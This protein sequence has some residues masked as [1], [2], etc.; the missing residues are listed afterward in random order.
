[1]DDPANRWMALKGIVA[2]GATMGIGCLARRMALSI[3]GNPTQTTPQGDLGL[4]LGLSALGVVLWIGCFGLEWWFVRQKSLFSRLNS[5]IL[6]FIGLVYVIYGF[7][8]IP[9]LQEAALSQWGQR[10]TA[11]V[12]EKPTTLRYDSD[13]GI[14]RNDYVLRYRYTLPQRPK[15]YDG[16]AGVK[17][18]YFDRIPQGEEITI[19]YW[20]WLPSWSVLEAAQSAQSRLPFLLTAIFTLIGWTVAVGMVVLAMGPI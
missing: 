19:Y 11:T 16:Q 1:M 8:L 6:V 10:A 17:K 14:T 13:T 18:S 15:P 2:L 9:F 7:W 3:V 5:L 4:L 20:P 12:T